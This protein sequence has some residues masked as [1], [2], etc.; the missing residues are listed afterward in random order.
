MATSERR[1][2]VGNGADPDGAAIVTETAPA[3]KHESGKK[4]AAADSA[5]EHR[6]N[7]RRKQKRRQA[8]GSAW[9]WKQTDC[10]YYTLPGT[11]KRMPLFDQDGKRICGVESKKAA[12]L[13]LA[14]LQLAGDWQAAAERPAAPE[15]W[16]VAKVCSEYLQ[17]CKRGEA[18]GSISKGHHENSRWILNELCKYCGALAVAE[19]KKGHIKTWIESHPKWKSPATHRSVISVTL[20]AF[21]YVQENFEIP[22]PLKGLKKP[23]SQPRLLSFSKEDEELLYTATDESFGQFLFA[24][25]RTGLRP[26]CE[27]AHITASDV[28]ET[29]RGMM[30]RVYSSKT[31]KTR[32]IPVRPDVAELTR[33]LMETA[34]AGSGKPVFRN[35]QGNRWLKVTGVWRFITMRRTLDWG[36]DPIRKK[37]SSYTCRHTFAH[38]MLSGYWNGGAGCSIETLA[39]LIGDTPKVAFDHYGKEWGQHYQEPLWAALGVSGAE[40][41]TEQEKD[42]GTPERSRPSNGRRPKKGSQ[43]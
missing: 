11:K 40:P 18:S 12:Q 20:A 16:L 13:A 5:G 19:L 10:W 17:Y 34:P 14:R 30:W 2:T 4:S 7:R 27:L 33:R 28:E 6:Q 41:T 31:K 37:Y 3:V 26:Y 36:N 29:P 15:E 25:I 21:N 9:H 32:K 1:K 24:A 43:A 22:N 42:S 35:P 8:H 38:R 23:K 39:E